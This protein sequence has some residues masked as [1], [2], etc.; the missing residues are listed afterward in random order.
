M[1]FKASDIVNNTSLKYYTTS[2]F[3]RIL[4]IALKLTPTIVMF[5]A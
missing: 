2:Y 1:K 4:I 3:I 5:K